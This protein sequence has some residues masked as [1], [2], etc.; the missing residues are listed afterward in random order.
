MYDVLPANRDL[1]GA[2]VELVDMDE[3]DYRLRHAL[4]PQLKNYDVVLIDCSP[5]I[6]LLTINALCCAHGVIIPMQCEYY[7]MEGLTDL[8]DT[9]KMVY[10][11]KNPDLTAIGLLRVMFD[12]RISLQQEVSEQLKEHFGNRV[13][14]T[15]IPRNV[16]LAEAPSYGMPI[17][18]YD[19]RSTG[20]ESYRLLADEVIHRGD[21]E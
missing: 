13:F 10:Q 19:K 9:V 12:A 2:E 4:E 14:N 21:E 1:A 15:I 11:G 5:S 8:V 6:S 16:R 7:A 18:Y 17:N 20:A 3:R